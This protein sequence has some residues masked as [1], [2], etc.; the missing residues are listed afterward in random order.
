MIFSLKSWFISELGGGIFSL[1]R[2]H[3]RISIRSLAGWVSQCCSYWDHYWSN[4][5]KQRFKSHKQHPLNWAQWLTINIVSAERR[6]TQR[7]EL[8][9]I[10]ESYTQNL[11]QAYSFS[12]GLLDLVRNKNKTTTWKC[13]HRFYLASHWIFNWPK[14]YSLKRFHSINQYTLYSIFD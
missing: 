6:H 5:V 13:H 9:A 12:L 8:R 7:K 3:E 10:Y 14:L 2:K 11:T 4:D 1:Y